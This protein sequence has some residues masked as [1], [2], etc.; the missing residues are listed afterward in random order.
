MPFKKI[1]TNLAIAKT[2]D[3]WK[4]ISS[5]I[6]GRDRKKECRTL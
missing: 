1:K 5:L 4:P 6:G 3:R 2:K